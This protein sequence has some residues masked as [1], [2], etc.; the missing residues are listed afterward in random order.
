MNQPATT[1]QQQQPSFPKSQG[2]PGECA[3]EVLK[4]LPDW[5]DVVTIVLHG[6]CVFEYKGPFPPGTVGRGFYNLQGSRPGFEG[7]LGLP[8]IDH[9]AFQ[10]REHA[11]RMAHALNFTSATGESLFK[12]FLGRNADGDIWPRQLALYDELKKRFT[13]II[14]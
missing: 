2:I 14:D 10:D 6:G 13:Q 9:I 11:G 7:H 8:A 1:A 12:V 4:S 5:G 3:L